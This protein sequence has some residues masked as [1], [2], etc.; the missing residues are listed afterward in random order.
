VIKC[1]PALKAAVAKVAL[2]ALSVPVPSRMLPSRKLTAPVG[3]PVPENGET[4]AVK[5]TDWF[6]PTGLAE[7]MSVVVVAIPVAA[8]TVWFA[9]TD[10]LPAKLASPEYT[11]VITWEPAANVEV[12]KVALPALNVPVPSVVLP[13]M[14]V[15]VPVALNVPADDGLTVA[16]KVTAW[17]ATAGLGAPVTAVVVVGLVTVWVNTADALAA[18]VESPL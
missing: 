5:V 13:S 4:V 3:V 11:A 17:P 1:G 7:L 16:V 10:V 12:V 15:T 8:F 6:K 2:P 14:K 18:K 9:P